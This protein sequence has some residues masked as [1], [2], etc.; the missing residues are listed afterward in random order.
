MFN[1]SLFASN[2][3]LLA[4]NESLLA[5][6]ES[7]LVYNKSLLICHPREG[8]DLAPS[9]DFLDPRLRGDDNRV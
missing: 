2:E 4:V 8:G 5:G 3:S 1:E 7:L 6:N 9:I